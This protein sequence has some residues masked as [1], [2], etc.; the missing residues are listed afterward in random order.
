MSVKGVGLKTL[1]CIAW[2]ISNSCQST[3]CVDT[4]EIKPSQYLIEQASL[5]HFAYEEHLKNAQ[6]N[7][8]SSLIKIIEFSSETDGENGLT[9]GFVLL[10]LQEKLGHKVF[11]SVLPHAS[12][13][14]QKR[15]LT[16]MRVAKKMK[17]KMGNL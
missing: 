12:A 15:A 8:E 4:S 17:K 10:K 13:E 6:R 11:N 3:K 5:V 9:H 16:L 14:A 2:F 1:L 7:Q